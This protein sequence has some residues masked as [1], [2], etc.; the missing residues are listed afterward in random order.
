MFSCEFSQISKKTFYTEHLWTIASTHTTALKLL[1]FSE[2]PTVA[3]WDRIGRVIPQACH[4]GFETLGRVF[5]T[6]RENQKLHGES[7]KLDW[8]FE[9]LGRV[10]EKLGRVFVLQHGP[11]CPSQPRQISALTF[12]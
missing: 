4:R 7:E 2:I 1:K 6:L 10:Y 3:D 9:K 5:E 8:V 11:R 12:V